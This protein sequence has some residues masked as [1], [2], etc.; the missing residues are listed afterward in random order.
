[1]PCMAGIEQLA[2]ITSV[3][4]HC[5]IGSCLARTRDK[6]NLKRHQCVDLNSDKRSVPSTGLGSLSVV[7]VSDQAE[8]GAMVLRMNRPLHHMRAWPRFLPG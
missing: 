2:A 4:S 1:M 5:S 8:S 6:L 7:V 3:R